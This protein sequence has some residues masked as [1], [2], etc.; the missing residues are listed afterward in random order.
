MSGAGLGNTGKQ[1][2]RIIAIV[3]MTVGGLFALIGIGLGLAGSLS[4]PWLGAAF[5]LG[6]GVMGAIVFAFGWVIFRGL[7]QQSG[8]A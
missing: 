7:R 6:W 3:L 4:D 8:G 1:V 2:T 5:A